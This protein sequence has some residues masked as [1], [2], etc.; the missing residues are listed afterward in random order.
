MP[1]PRLRATVSGWRDAHLQG[2]RL[3]AA[4]QAREPG[5]E[6]R[7]T[8]AAATHGRAGEAVGRVHVEQ[9]GRAWGQTRRRGGHPCQ[10]L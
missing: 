6:Q 8:G 3:H 4:V 1:G 9:R 7:G 2:Q 10:V 5:V